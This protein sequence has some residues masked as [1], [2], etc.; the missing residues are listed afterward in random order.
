[1]YRWSV[2]DEDKFEKT[3]EM[4]HTIRLGGTPLDSAI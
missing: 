3:I 1:M 2:D 4:P